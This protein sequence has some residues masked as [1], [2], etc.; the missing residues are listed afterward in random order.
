MVIY[1]IVA[2]N[3]EMTWSDYQDPKGFHIFDTETREMERIWNP[4]NNS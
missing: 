1:F 3:I 2:L 4:S